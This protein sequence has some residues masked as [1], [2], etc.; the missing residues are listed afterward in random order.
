[1]SKRGRPLKQLSE[2]T[3]SVAVKVK[4]VDYARTNGITINQYIKSLEE[5][6]KHREESIEFLQKEIQKLNKE[7]DMQNEINLQLDEAQ[8]IFNNYN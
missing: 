6:I 1:M 4:Y 2:R 8:E 5:A 3:I 7:K